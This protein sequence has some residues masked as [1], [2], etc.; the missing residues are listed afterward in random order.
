MK[1]WLERNKKWADQKNLGNKDYFSHLSKGQSPA[2]LW[3]GCCDSRV[4]PTEFLNL[5]LGDIFLQSNIA[6]QVKS[7]DEAMVAAINFAVDVLK[8]QQI[9]VCGHTGCGGVHGSLHPSPSVPESVARW[10]SPLTERY[11]ERVAKGE[12]TEGRVVELNV[13]DQVKHLKAILG[14]RP[15]LPPIIGLVFRLEDGQ[16]YEPTQ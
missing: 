2:L 1:K 3:I 7:D 12:L 15:G 4:T 6:N 16:L 11:S 5:S 13:Q 10:V 9:V 14:D 8:V